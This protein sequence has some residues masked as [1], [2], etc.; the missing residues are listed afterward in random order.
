MTTDYPPEKLATKS[1]QKH[2]ILYSLLTRQSVKKRP[3]ALNGVTN[4]EIIESITTSF[5]ERIPSPE[6]V[7]LV[8]ARRSNNFPSVSITVNDS[9]SCFELDAESNCTTNTS[10]MRSYSQYDDIRGANNK[11][12]LNRQTQSLMSERSYQN[13]QRNKDGR[14]KSSQRSVGAK[15]DG[16]AAKTLSAILLAFICTW[17]PYMLFTLINSLGKNENDSGTVLPTTLYSIGE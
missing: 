4:R 15:H 9:D 17:S 16:K 3:P 10:L 8:S 7:A 12:K 14:G 13:L 6:H 1:S 2:S 11:I 5:N